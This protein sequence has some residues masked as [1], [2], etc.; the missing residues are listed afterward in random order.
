MQWL[1]IVIVIDVS[2]HTWI[3][4]IC[5]TEYYTFVRS[6]IFIAV[7]YD[8]QNYSRLNVD[9]LPEFFY[10]NLLRLCTQLFKIYYGYYDKFE[11]VRKALNK[12]RYQSNVFHGKVTYIPIMYRSI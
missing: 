7:L 4:V 9:L 12:E 10:I 3:T 8:E 11:Q 5:V 1:S 6:K 2:M